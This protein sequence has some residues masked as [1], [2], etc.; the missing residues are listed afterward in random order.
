[1]WVPEFAVGTAKKSKKPTRGSGGS[2]GGA[3]SGAVTAPMQGTI[4]KVM[5][6]VGQ[7]IAVGDAVAV[8]EA[9]KM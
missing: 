7:T 4:V 8:L 3:A 6:E 5:V 2:G 9:M 1:M